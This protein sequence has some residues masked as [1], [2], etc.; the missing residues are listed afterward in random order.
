MKATYHSSYR[1]FKPEQKPGTIVALSDVHFPGRVTADMHRALMFAKEQSPNLIV[2]P[3]DL[4]DNLD[5]VSCETERIALRRWLE[6]LGQIAPVCLCIG[7]HD[8]YY[9]KP[10]FRSGLAGYGYASRQPD[11]LLALVNSIPNVH[12]LDNEFYM[13][14]RYCVYSLTLPPEYYDCELHPGS[15]DFKVFIDALKKVSY[16]FEKLPKRKTKI[17]LVHSPAFLKEKAIRKHL[18]NFD[19]ILAGHM[20]NGVVP[21]LLH[22]IWRSHAGIATPD[23]KFFRDH[24]C[25]LGLYD[26]QFICLGAVTTVHK[27]SKPLGWAN[28]FFPTY[29]ATI[30]VG[31]NSADAKKPDV[32]HK[33]E[34]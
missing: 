5:A 25:R 7:N 21:P 10:N 19:F 27:G 28:S 17:L 24:N 32:K 22:E 33:Y 20:H 9:K 1:F 14:A 18:N 13:D 6:K 15:E 34:R 31:H 8:F 3:G 29:V 12:F 30:K 26:D 11:D 16:A 23:K 4:V 2:I